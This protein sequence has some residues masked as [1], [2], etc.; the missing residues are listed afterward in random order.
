MKL[1]NRYI[2]AWGDFEIPDE[3]Y[4]NTTWL[5][6]EYFL[7]IE[8]PVEPLAVPENWHFFKWLDDCEIEAGKPNS[9][10]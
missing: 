10:V 8:K 6:K 9:K 4:K 1:N 2:T 3:I 5:K 7:G